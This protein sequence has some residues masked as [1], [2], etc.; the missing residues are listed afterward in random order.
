VT[1]E[2]LETEWDQQFRNFFDEQESWPPPYMTLEHK[3]R[4]IE[5]GMREEGS[6]QA[7]ENPDTSIWQ[8]LDQKLSSGES[9]WENRNRCYQQTWR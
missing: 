9:I 1:R 6:K 5:Q 2:L 8:V 7:Q 4:I 3:R